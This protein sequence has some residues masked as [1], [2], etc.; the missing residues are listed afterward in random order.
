MAPWPIGSFTSRPEDEMR[1]V[2]IHYCPV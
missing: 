2:D 1:R